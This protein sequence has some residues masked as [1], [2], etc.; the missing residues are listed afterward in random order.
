MLLG[1]EDE[2]DEKGRLKLPEGLVYDDWDRPINPMYPHR[3]PFTGQYWGRVHRE[4]RP[5]RPERVRANAYTP[6]EARPERPTRVREAREERAQYIPDRPEYEG[7]KAEIE[8]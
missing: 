2:F 6:R 7:L 1:E 4:R 5:K 8:A 3:N